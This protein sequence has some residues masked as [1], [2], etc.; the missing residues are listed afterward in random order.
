[1]VDH[2]RVTNHGSETEEQFLAR[3]MRREAA[4][5][6]VKNQAGTTNM[7][8]VDDIHGDGASGKVFVFGRTATHVYH[9]EKRVDY[10]GVEV[11]GY[12][13]VN[14]TTFS[15]ISNDYDPEHT[16]NLARLMSQLQPVGPEAIPTQPGFCLDGVFL[17]DSLRD[18]PRPE[19]GESI[20]MFAGL[21]GHEDLGIALSTIAGTAPGPG[22]IERTDANRVGPYAFLN[23]FTSTLL[24]GSRTINGLE[25]EEL[26]IKVREHN[27]TTGYAFDWETRGTGDNVLRPFVSLELQTGISPHAD[28]APRQSSLS[29]AS[30]GDVWRRMSSSLR[31]HSVAVSPAP[32]PPH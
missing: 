32:A 31:L 19:Q 24:K 3:L 1:M 11:N 27:L 14:G 6:A 30:L 23:L 8:R 13:N 16:G 4:I 18:L 15:F 26:A 20:V 9:G 22:L 28:G 29:E 12:V 21:P 5:N 10:V 7:E 17:R 2:F 25:G